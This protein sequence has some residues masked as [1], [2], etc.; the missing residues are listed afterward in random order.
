VKALQRERG[1]LKA[2][3]RAAEIAI[4]DADTLRPLVEQQFAE[5]AA[6]TDLGRDAIHA[7]FRGERTSVRADA[8]AGFRVEGTAW[9]R[10]PANERAARVDDPRAALQDGSGGALCTRTPGVVGDIETVVA[11]DR[12]RSE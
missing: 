2:R 8:A 3:L 6:V 7:L 10:F 11:G 1:V 9:L 12:H 4:P 5:L